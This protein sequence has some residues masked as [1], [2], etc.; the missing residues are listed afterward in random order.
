MPLDAERT[1]NA[2]TFTSE[3]ESA[4]ERE[5]KRFE[6]RLRA[7][8]IETSIRARGFPAEVTGTDVAK[9][10]ADLGRVIERKRSAEIDS[11]IFHSLTPPPY[12]TPIEEKETSEESRVKRTSLYKLFTIYAWLGVITAVI[13]FLYPIFHD[14]VL[15]LLHSEVGRQ[16]I[17]L[18]GSGVLFAIVA[19]AA[20]N[21]IANVSTRKR[22]PVR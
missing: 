18:T 4:V 12:F 21:W 17:L 14:S 10:S 6:R 7:K 11:E 1:E 15:N 2:V 5:V 9:T 3:A 19:F 20:R 16:G 13:G 8:S 22:R